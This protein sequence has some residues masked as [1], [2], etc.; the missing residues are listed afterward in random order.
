VNPINDR[1]TPWLEKAMDLSY[2]RNTVL[3]GNLANI[4]TPEYEPKDL[5]FQDRLKSE[6]ETSEMP[7]AAP[8]IE[9]RAE[10]EPRLDGNK[11]DLDG[12]VARITSNR[13]FY[14]LS[15]EVLTRRLA[16]IRYAIDEGGR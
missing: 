9:T 8:Q 7:N 11:V 13:L 1:L 4:D 3:T 16:R 6:L 14:Q 2:R 15:T 5:E 12:E 10:A